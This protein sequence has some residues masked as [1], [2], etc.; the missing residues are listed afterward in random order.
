MHCVF[1]S[2]CV[3]CERKK[4]ERKKESAKDA[5]RLFISLKN[6]RIELSVLVAM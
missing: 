6:E 5:V 1:V 3:L 4:R 2:V